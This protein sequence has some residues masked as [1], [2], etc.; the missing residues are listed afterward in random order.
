MNAG[1]AI[2]AL[3]ALDQPEAVCEAAVRNATWPARMQK[4]D[5]G[6]LVDMAAPAELWLDG[7]HNP[8][9][10]IAL[11]DTLRQQ[12]KRRTH[13]I[14]GMLNT[15]DIAGYLA[16]LA[17]VADHLTGVSIPDEVNTI[18]GEET[19]RIAT[20]VG[21]SADT[22]ETLRAAIAAATATDPHAR[23]LICGSLYFAGHALR[24]NGTSLK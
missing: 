6:T 8:A 22:A 1:A 3:R 13:L 19:A 21:L 12:P 4:L 20:S 9:A 11:A 24:E 10:G 18:P 23:I 15:K 7:G 5:S 2:A 14:C 17:A 16:P